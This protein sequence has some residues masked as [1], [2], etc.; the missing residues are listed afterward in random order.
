MAIAAPLL[1]RAS[2]LPALWFLM[3]G[4]AITLF[5]G[6]LVLVIAEALVPSGTMPGPLYLARGL[7]KLA[8]RARR[9][10]QITRILVRRGMLPYLRGSRRAELR[11]RDGRVQLAR[12]L[13]RAL[14]DGGVIH[15]ART[16]TRDAARP[17]AG[18]VHRR[19]ERPARRRPAGPWSEVEQLLR[20]E[21]GAEVDDVF[22]SFDRT[23]LAAAS[24][25]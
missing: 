12:S 22:A 11:T 25:A 10:S 9:Y 6:M 2:V 13:R 21:L 16:G 17:A 3:L 1:H 4:T 20:S 19:T 23:P 7:R 18:R 15:Q 24:I 14:E 8:R 5:V